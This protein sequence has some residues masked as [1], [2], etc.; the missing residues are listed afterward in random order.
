MTKTILWIDGQNRSG[1]NAGAVRLELR[2]VGGQY[3]WYGPSFDEDGNPTGSCSLDTG[4][5]G[6]TQGEAMDAAKQAWSGPA[7]NLRQTP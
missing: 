1:Y 2:R 7:W 4:V 5:G 6:R 3:R